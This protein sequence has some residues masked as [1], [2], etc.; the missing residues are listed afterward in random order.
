MLFQDGN[1]VTP[2]LILPAPLSALNI[3][4]SSRILI[5]T[6]PPLITDVYAITGE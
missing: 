1:E 3:V 5:D 6:D 4:G 2:S